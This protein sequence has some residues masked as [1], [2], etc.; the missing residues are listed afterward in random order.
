[1][2]IRPNELESSIQKL[3]KEYG[4]DVRTAVNVAVPE[5]AK[6]AAKQLRKTSPSDTGDYRRNWSVKKESSRTDVKSTV[7]NAKH[8]RLTHLLEYGHVLKTG[9]RVAGGRYVV[10]TTGFVKARPHIAK[11]EA[12]AVQELEER[13]KEAVS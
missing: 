2:N 6:E 12:W 11:V 13:V 4:D 5:V 9:K 1:M 10:E 8:Y 7:Y 3:L